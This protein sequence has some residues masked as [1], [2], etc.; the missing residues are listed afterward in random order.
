LTKS[1]VA[2]EKLPHEK[3]A[4]IKSRQDAL[5]TI[6][7]GHLDIFYPPNLAVLDK[8]RLFQL[9]RLISTVMKFFSAGDLSHVGRLET[10]HAIATSRIP[11][12]LFQEDGEVGKCTENGRVYSSAR[13]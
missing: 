6:F 9:P 13:L 7:S 1:D 8:R 2:V 11:S 12:W 5:Q 4:K 3:I 10:A